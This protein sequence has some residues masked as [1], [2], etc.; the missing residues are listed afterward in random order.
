M[1]TE[2][3]TPDLYTLTFGRDNP[4]NTT[5]YDASGLALYTVAT[6]LSNISKPVTR[7]HRGD[8]TL[9]AEWTWRGTLRSDL[10]TF[11]GRPTAPAS[12]W[13]KKSKMPFTSTATF[14]AKGRE[15]KWANN[16]PG[17]ALQ[18]FAPESKSEPVARYTRQHA[19]RSADDP[20]TVVPSRLLIKGSVQDVQDEIVVSFLLLERRRREKE[21]D[22]VSRASA[23]AVDSSFGQPVS[24]GRSAGSAGYGTLAG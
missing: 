19:D 13:L 10:L 21:S 3:T 16:A 15:L 9:V 7:L 18:L 2:S 23:V 11:P 24:A 12:D 6:D 5:I 1:T 8:A 17:L 14:T 4:S 20:T 22:A